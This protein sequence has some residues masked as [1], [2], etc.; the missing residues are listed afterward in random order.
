VQTQ[1]AWKKVE[2]LT[3][4]TEELQKKLEKLENRTKEESAK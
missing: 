2:A 4:K 3:Q 1:Q